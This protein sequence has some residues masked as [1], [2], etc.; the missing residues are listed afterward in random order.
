MTE[1]I[2]KGNDI[3]LETKTIFDTESH[4]NTELHAVELPTVVETYRDGSDWYRIWSDG[5][6]EQG[7]TQEFTDSWTLI[8]PVAYAD[9]NYSLIGEVWGSDSTANMGITE[10]TESTAKGNIS[11]SSGAKITWEA[12]GY[13][14]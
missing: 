13:I 6:C 4:P 10:L 7:G 11:G 14:I 12:K 8:L 2:V 1:T 5:W 9:A 3:Y